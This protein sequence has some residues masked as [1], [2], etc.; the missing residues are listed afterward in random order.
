MRAFC[1]QTPVAELDAGAVLI[2]KLKSSPTGKRAATV[3]WAF[4]RLSYA[5]SEARD[6]VVLTMFKRPTDLKLRKCSP[7]D[8]FVCVDVEVCTR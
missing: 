5:A 1:T 3:A 4:M 6:G 7:A 8:M 2:I